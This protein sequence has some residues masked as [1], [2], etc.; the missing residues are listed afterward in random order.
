MDLINK[1]IKCLDEAI[2]TLKFEISMYRKS[3]EYND[4]IIRGYTYF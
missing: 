3:S 2:D 1:F 4:Q